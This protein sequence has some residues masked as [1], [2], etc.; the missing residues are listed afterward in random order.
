MIAFWMSCCCGGGLRTL[1]MILV[2]LWNRVIK[3]SATKWACKVLGLFDGEN[4]GI[5]FCWVELFSI[6]LF[7]YFLIRTCRKYCALRGL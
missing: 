3:K 7:W 2:L 1:M 4:Y 5:L 6:C